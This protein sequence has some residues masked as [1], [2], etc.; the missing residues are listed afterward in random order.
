VGDFERAG[1]QPLATVLTTASAIGLFGEAA[2]RWRLSSGRWQRP[3]RGVLITH[4]GPA[5]GTEALW[6][7]V[8]ALGPQAV[9][10]GL[11]A[12]RLDGLTGFQ[13]Q[14]V[15]LVVPATRP[16]RTSLP[17][18]VVHRSRV[19]GADDVHPLRRPARTRIA[20]S[21]LDAAAWA[22]SDDAARSI[23]P[24]GVQQR[25]TRADHL[26][27]VLARFPT[28]R[29]HALLA[30][31]LADIAGGAEA[32]S[33]LDFARL[34]RRYRLPE[35]DRQAMRV[36]GQGRRRWLDAFWDEAGLVVEVDGLWHMEAAAW[37]A[38]MRR[39][40]DLTI[41]GLRVLRFPAFALRDS[42]GVVA[43]Q[44]GAALGLTGR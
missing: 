14:G 38:D 27:M 31:T 11:T 9:L 7:A 42:P 4:S 3:H 35:P 21:L 34:A 28:I 43:G 6:V 16:V 44:I 39:E 15:H 24:A 33:E 30:S 20:R 32:L 13:A 41:S 12:A 5:S 40:N 17:G 2:V 23:L 10:G 19:L 37:W 18:V 25:L 36:D 8:L 1:C 26:A 22:R 29:R